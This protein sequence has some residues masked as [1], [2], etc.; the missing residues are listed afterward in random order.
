MFA[1]KGWNVSAAALKTQTQAIPNISS[2]ATESK[3][4]KDN[5]SGEGSEKSSSKKRKRGELAAPTS[6]VTDENVGDLWGT[7]I[8]GK[9]PNKR[10]RAKL[11]KQKLEED[12][13]NGVVPDV[14][15]AKQP[16]HWNQQAPTKSE[17]EKAEREAEVK[18]SRKDKKE[19]NKKRKGEATGSATTT[20]SSDAAKQVAAGVPAAM[21][22]LPVNAKLTPMQSAMRQKLISARFRH[23]NETLYTA[24]ST[25]SLDLF[26]QNPEMF[27]DYHSGFRQQVTTWPEN[28]VDSFIRMIRERGTVK[29]PRSQKQMF[30]EKKKGKEVEGDGG[31]KAGD[32]LPR[33]HGTAILADLGCG[34]AR[35]AQTLTESKD[36]TKLNLKIHSFDL[37]SPSPYVT[38]A[39]VANLPLADGS[40]DVAIFCLALMG[41]NWIDFI[42]EAYRI[43]HWKGE[44]W[45]AEIKSRFGRVGGSDGL[46]AKKGKPVEHS[47]G[48]KKKLAALK[49]KQAQEALIKDERD[50]D[51]ALRTEVDEDA[52]ALSREE[53]DVSAFIEVLRRRGF[54]LKNNES[55]SVDLSNKMFVRFEFIKAAAPVVGKNFDPEQD[56]ERAAAKK[57]GETWKPKDKKKFIEND[58][59]EDKGPSVEDEAKVLKPCLYKIR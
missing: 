10:E 6:Q 31:E 2:K 19:A 27:D 9:K 28:P 37:Q 58:S 50:D 54:V 22:S 5:G 44:L 29:G 12:L 36:V 4:D 25:T 8:E 40:V 23:L 33:T 46:N 48:N 21:P 13:K 17:A 38:K 47:V 35:I 3:K 11:K 49:K 59:R 32:P 20:A 43:L 55:S 57:G 41:T 1:V 42:E 30:R 14:P 15:E 7:A 16:V 18:K 26:S 53:T 52:P 39:D 56:A 51:E 24:P 34:D 45:I